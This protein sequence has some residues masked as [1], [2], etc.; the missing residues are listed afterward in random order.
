MTVYALAS[1][2]SLQMTSHDLDLS[3][4]LAKAT[5]AF[6]SEQAAWT[7][8]AEKLTKS[9][10]NLFLGFLGGTFADSLARLHKMALE[11]CSVEKFRQEAKNSL[12][13][14]NDTA[15]CFLRN[16]AVYK[17]QKEKVVHHLDRFDERLHQSQLSFSSFEP[18]SHHPTET[19]HHSKD[20]TAILKN[21]ANGKLAHQLHHFKGPLPAHVYEII[22]SAYVAPKPEDRTSPYRDLLISSSVHAGLSQAVQTMLFRTNL[23]ACTVLAASDIAAYG[24]RETQPLLDRLAE[25]R[26]MAEYWNRSWL[27]S[28]QE[29]PTFHSAVTSASALLSLAQVPS[30][31][32]DYVHH[33]ATDLIASIGDSLGLTDESVNE[34][35]E[36]SLEQIDKLAPMLLDPQFWETLRS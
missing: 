18:F 3:R 24:A 5:E 30:Q 31:L 25:N 19:N 28:G 20:F 15:A 17:E 9:S 23:V 1:S 35:V 32:I 8:H 7:Q 16:R 14:I 36:N 12:G 21:W 2:S 6:S 33:E 10:R 27:L 22:A 34:V 26:E 4:E 13:H 11:G 29:G